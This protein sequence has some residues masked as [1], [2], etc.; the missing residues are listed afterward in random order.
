MTIY[1]IGSI[2]IDTTFRV[3]HL[4]A[5]G[6]T[7]AATSVTRQ[8]GG[9]GANQSVAIARA[10]AAV[11]HIGAV[12]T[13]GRPQ[14][15]QMQSFGV[16]TKHIA[17]LDNILTGQAIIQV[18]DAGENAITLETGANGM[19]DHAWIDRALS[20][21]STSDT[22]VLQNETNDTAAFAAA[23]R[24]RGMKIIWSAAPYDADIAK[25]MV[26]LVNL[27]VLN[28]TE[29]QQLST[30][31]I[32]PTRL[33]EI[34]RLVTAGSAGAT[35]FAPQA[36][37]L[38]VSAHKVQAADTTGAGDTYIGTFIAALDSGATYHDAMFRASATAALHVT[39]AGA[40]N[41]IPHRAEVDQWLETQSEKHAQ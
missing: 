13:D 22:L 31:N 12:G 11:V 9:K 7:I 36:E 41:S 24:E 21:A 25:Q 20:S 16:D 29:M 14:L 28:E 30:S 1:N 23:G 3:P 34:Q 19:L 35:Y 5:P 10:G 6:E 8:L 18:D 39:R 37:P 2:N 15:A 32:D 27:I 40:A 38:Y 33:D 17:V 4:P 26:P